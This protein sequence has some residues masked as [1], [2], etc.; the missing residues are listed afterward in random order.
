VVFELVYF[1]LRKSFFPKIG[2]CSINFAW[3]VREVFLLYF[4]FS[5]LLEK[6]L[7]QN[8]TNSSY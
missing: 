3:A 6:N 5:K 1:S 4:C 2:G 7:H 8:Q